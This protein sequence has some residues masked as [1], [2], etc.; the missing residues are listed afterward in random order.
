MS[1]AKECPSLKRNSLVNYGV[2]NGRICAGDRVQVL[3]ETTPKNYI[4]TSYCQLGAFVPITAAELEDLMAM[5]EENREQGRRGRSSREAVTT[6]RGRAAARGDGA[7]RR[8][9]GTHCGAGAGRRLASRPV[10]KKTAGQ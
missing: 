10:P 1:F 3:W 4:P 7:R 9:D 8:R 2:R 5:T 6:E